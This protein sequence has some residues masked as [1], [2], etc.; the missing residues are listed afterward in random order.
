[1]PSFILINLLIVSYH[2]TTGGVAWLYT[3]EVGIDAASGFTSSGQFLTLILISF[4]FEYM[5]NS[6]L[7]VYGTMLCFGITTVLGG[8]LLLCFVRETRGLTDIEKK[9]LYSPKSVTFTDDHE[10]D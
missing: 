4:T 9:T 7:Q 2:W 3:A 8:F 5:I 6:S 10:D 1:M